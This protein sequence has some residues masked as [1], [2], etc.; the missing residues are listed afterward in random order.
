MRI[1]VIGYGNS[2]RG[3]DGIGQLVAERLQ[4]EFV[5]REDRELSFI[6]G[7]Q[8][9]PEHAK[10]LAE[11]DIALFIDA[12]ID[13]TRE[14]VALTC[15]SHGVQSSSSE[16]SALGSSRPSVGVVIHSLGPVDLLQLTADLYQSS[17]RAYLLS[18]PA[19]SFEPG[20]PL[21]EKANIAAEKAV[22]LASA[23]LTECGSNLPSLPNLE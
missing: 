17:P 10:D 7:E 23:F 8:L 4:S 16:N 20:A 19:S 14:S 1:V 9:Y 13:T 11:S 21:S 18:I 5:S 2:I 22:T 3:D 15:I 6:C 12:H